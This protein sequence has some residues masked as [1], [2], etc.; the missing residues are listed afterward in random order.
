MACASATIKSEH[1]E[2]RRRVEPIQMYDSTFEAILNTILPLYPPHQR[3]L[4]GEFYIVTAFVLIMVIR[5]VAYEGLC[6][7]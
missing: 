3:E 5:G 2:F 7:V 6:P 1:A 4:Y